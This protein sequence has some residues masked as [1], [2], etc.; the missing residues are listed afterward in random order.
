MQSFTYF[1]L[2]CSISQILKSY[3]L[4]DCEAPIKK[5]FIEKLTVKLN[6]QPNK[7]SKK[8]KFPIQICCCNQ[9]PS[10]V[11][12]FELNWINLLF[13]IHTQTPTDTFTMDEAFVHPLKVIYKYDKTRLEEIELPE[14][15]N[16]DSILTRI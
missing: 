7:V 15:L 1:N 9:Q 13:S 16:L 6:E 10:A 5:A 4:D 3:T 11:P 2:P 14:I 12:Y 8:K